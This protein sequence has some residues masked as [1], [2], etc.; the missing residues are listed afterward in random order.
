LQITQEELRKIYEECGGDLQ[1]IS[2]RLG[3][4]LNEF[5]NTIMPPSHAGRRRIPPA[6]IGHRPGW[7]SPKHIVAV[8]YCDGS[9]AISDQDKIDKARE[10]YEAG[11]HEMV[12]GRDRD[13][14]VLFSIPRKKRC[15]ARKFFAQE[16]FN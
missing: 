16:S 5:P 12:T 14:F 4:P 8:R 9:W 2:A 15:G 11:T 13:W 3:V 6:D 7:P 10:H 1:K